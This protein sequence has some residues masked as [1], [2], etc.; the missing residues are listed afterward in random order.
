MITS[1][2]FA[3][4]DVKLPLNLVFRLSNEARVAPVPTVNTVSGSITSAAHFRI[5]QWAVKLTKEEGSTECF[6][7]ISK[8]YH[9]SHCSL[10]ETT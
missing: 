2:I 1:K 5:L 10:L 4:I 8:K 6:I 7:R 3:Q 9:L